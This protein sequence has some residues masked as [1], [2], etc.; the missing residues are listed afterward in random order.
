MNNNRI[1][2]MFLVNNLGSGGAEHQLLQLVKGIDKKRFKPITVTL[3]P[4]G[5]LEKDMQQ[6]TGAELFTVNRKGKY[7]FWV[8]KRIVSLMRHQNVDVVQPFLS[9][10]TFFGLIPALINHVPLKIVTERS[11][12]GLITRFGARSYQKVEDFFTRFADWVVPNSSTGR[13]YLIKR[14]INPA[15]IKVIYNGLNLERLTPDKEKVVQIR[16]QLNLPPGGKVVGISANLRP[17]K[18]HITF[19]RA[20]KI[21]NQTFPDTRYAILGDGTER[22]NLE[23]LVRELSMESLVTF[24]GYQYDIASYLACFD[25]ACLCSK[26]TEGCPMATLEAMAL[27]KTVVVTNVGGNTEVVEHG[28]NGLLVSPE[29]PQAL[30][31]SVIDCLRQPDRAGEMAQRAKEM[32]LN[33][34]SLTRF[35]SDYENLY[36]EAL[37]QNNRK[38]K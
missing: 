25:I 10:S 24:F 32:V 15:R 35:I 19:L 2:V 12:A 4:G 31:N 20:A 27:G 13:D 1:T 34:F 17:D 14:G 9:P 28:R 33:R 8:L 38:R 3:Y 37:R 36:E 6:I 29:N 30:A 23:N 21:I 26:Y 16:N 22:Q 11:G 18:D 5:P 7:D